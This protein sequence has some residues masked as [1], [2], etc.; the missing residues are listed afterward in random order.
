M[1]R[2]DKV[3]TIMQGIGFFLISLLILGTSAAW[4]AEPEEI[5]SIQPVPEFQLQDCGIGEYIERGKIKKINKRGVVIDDGMLRF[6][7]STIFLSNSGQS[8]DLSVFRVGSKIG[9]CM[10]KKGEILI[11]WLE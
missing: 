2:R 5:L 1:M 7:P 10:G 8:V 6:S 4:A 9:M 3:I 11:M